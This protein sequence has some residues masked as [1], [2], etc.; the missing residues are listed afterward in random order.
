MCVEYASVFF[1]YGQVIGGLGGIRME[2]P[3]DFRTILKIFKSLKPL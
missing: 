1:L 2:W 3:P